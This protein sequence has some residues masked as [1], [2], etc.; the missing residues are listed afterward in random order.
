MKV[1]LVALSVFGVAQSALAGK[2]SCKNI[3]S[4]VED[5]NLVDLTGESLESLRNKRIQGTKVIVSKEGK[6]LFLFSG[7]S[8]LRVYNVALGR[9]PY[10]HKT[11]EGDNKTPEGVYQ[12]DFKKNDSEYHKALHVNYP[13]KADLERTK[14]I[15]QNKGV[16]LS[17][18][19]DIMIH[20]LPNDDTSRFF[21]DKAH[22]IINWTRGCIAV[23]NEEI[24]E[25]YQLVPVKTELEIC[26]ANERGASNS[27][28]KIAEDIA[29]EESDLKSISIPGKAQ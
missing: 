18:G 13:N 6:R 9:S 21:V 27:A 14:R 1:L 24:D 23:T 16:D 5:R 3:D 20:G 26:P 4:I 25:L 7:D 11:Q 22:P 19:G 12:I 8:L 28:L 29:K 17:P 10:G 15:S 2:Y